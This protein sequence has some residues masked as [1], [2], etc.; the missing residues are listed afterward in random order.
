[1]KLLK[2]IFK[3]LIITLSVFII[4]ISILAVYNHIELKKEARQIIPNGKMV[5]L[6]L[7]KV[8]VYTE[9]ENKKAPTLV[10]LSGSGTVAPVYD[11]KV[12]YSL[13]SD[14]YKIAVV[15]KA[16]YGYSDIINLKRDVNIMVNELRRALIKADINGPYILIPHSMSGLE[17]IYWAQKF[18]EEISGIIGID[19]A[20]PSSYDDFD[21]EK[22][23][24]MMTLANI[25]AKLGLLRIPYIYPLS[26]LALNETEIYQQ[27][28]LMY[29]NALNPIYLTE[30]KAIYNN[31]QIVKKGDPIS[32]PI[33]MFLSNGKET[34]ESW[35]LSQ[36]EYAKEND[37]KIISFDCGHYIHHYKS[38][39]MADS[40][41]LFI[42][43]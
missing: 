41:K 42:E 19:M 2:K 35:I 11:F 17:A 32:C 16:G 43:K 10:F 33:L 38:D 24:Q 13:L 18:P 26:E 21:F 12:L 22:T 29:R 15:E 36:K 1:M 14:K 37:A 39:E 25:S 34:G 3:S 27:K 9:G 4:L 6:N 28:L 7:Y 8:H 23:N 20:V 30:G 40:I 5:N 31:A